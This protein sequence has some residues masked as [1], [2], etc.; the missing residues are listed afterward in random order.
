M[1]ILP[2][3]V[4]LAAISSSA[5]TQGVVTLTDSNFDAETASGLWLL[6]FY[7]PW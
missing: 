7:A 3:L 5:A 6:E 1:S 4:G 2:V